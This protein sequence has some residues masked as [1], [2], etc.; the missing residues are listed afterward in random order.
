MNRFIYTHSIRF[1]LSSRED[2]TCHFTIFSSL[3]G[4]LLK[5]SKESRE[6]KPCFHSCLVFLLLEHSLEVKL[7]NSSE[8]IILCIPGI[9]G[10]EAKIKRAIHHEKVKWLAIVG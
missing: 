10:C 1:V 3:G 4:C 8:P 6:F 9:T 5:E 7:Q 2:E